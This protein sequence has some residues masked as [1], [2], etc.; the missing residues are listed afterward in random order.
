MTEQDKKLAELEAKAVAEATATADDSFTPS[1]TLMNHAEPQ[2][3]MDQVD[4][5]SLKNYEAKESIY[6]GKSVPVALRSKLEVPIN[7]TAPGS[8][9]E[10]KVETRTYDISFGITA[11]RE[12]GVTVVKSTGRVESH[13]APVSGKF[14]VGSV[15][16]LLKFEFDNS[17][18]MFREKLLSYR[19]V[20]TPPSVKTLVEGR[21]RRAKACQRALSTDLSD[22]AVKHSSAVARKKDLEDKIAKLNQELHEAKQQLEMVA[23][24][25]SDLKTRVDLRKGQTALLEER[26]TRGWIDEPEEMKP[27]QQ[28][29]N[30]GQ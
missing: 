20:V 12:E 25:E 22:V 9:V 7:V 15:P 1:P 29:Q 21:R 30:G 3:L 26:L 10:Y 18:S 17:Y 19:V 28:Q 16:C 4:G 8:V 27:Q 5:P 13:V 24:E 11:E 23:T 2:V 14:L 6:V